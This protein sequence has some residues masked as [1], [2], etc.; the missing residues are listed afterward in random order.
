MSQVAKKIPTKRKYIYY[1]IRE[2][3]VCEDSK[4][5]DQIIVLK[6]PSIP[7]AKL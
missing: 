3:F 2:H 6:V 1:P 5:S 4:F 7:Q